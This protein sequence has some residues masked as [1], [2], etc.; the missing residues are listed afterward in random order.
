MIQRL[1]HCLHRKS[2]LV[3]V[4]PVDPIERMSFYDVCS[5]LGITADNYHFAEACRAGKVTEQVWIDMYLVPN[6]ALTVAIDEIS[7]KIDALSKRLEGV[8]E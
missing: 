7:A 1:L 2:D 6:A 3:P 5:H 8:P 4:L